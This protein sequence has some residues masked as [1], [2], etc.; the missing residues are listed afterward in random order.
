MLGEAFNAEMVLGT[1][2]HPH[3][4]HVLSSSCLL[5]KLPSGYSTAEE[6]T[7]FQGK[8]SPGK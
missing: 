6:V 5:P 3:A 8:P 2:K 7:H 4:K 1:W